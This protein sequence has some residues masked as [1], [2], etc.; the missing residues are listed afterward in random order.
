MHEGR[1]GYSESTRMAGY[2]RRT[3]GVKKH[4][5]KEI[6]TECSLFSNKRSRLHLRL[7]DY[8]SDF[9]SHYVW[10]ANKFTHTYGPLNLHIGMMATHTHTSLSSAHQ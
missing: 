9:I 2:F 1:I 3:S 6:T 7:T 4:A 10:T 5:K 8:L